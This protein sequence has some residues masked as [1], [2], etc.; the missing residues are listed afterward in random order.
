MGLELVKFAAVLCLSFCC[1]PTFREY[2]E[3]CVKKGHIIGSYYYTLTVHISLLHIHFIAD[4]TCRFIIKPIGNGS[5]SL[6]GFNNRKHVDAIE[7]ENFSLIPSN[8]GLLFTF[9]RNYFHLHLNR[10]IALWV[11]QIATVVVKSATELCVFNYRKHVH[12]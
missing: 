12:F 11:I 6:V 3:R 9:S 4:K 2:L 1:A 7:L 10:T 5:A 8:T